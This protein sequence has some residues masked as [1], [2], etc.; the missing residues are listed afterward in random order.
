MLLCSRLL[1]LEDEPEGIIAPAAAF[2][3]AAIPDVSV[4]KLNLEYK[5]L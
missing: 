1:E 2:A 5:K 3:P 4:G